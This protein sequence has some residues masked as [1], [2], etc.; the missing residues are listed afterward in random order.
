MLA[1]K[2]LAS[3]HWAAVTGNG[4]NWGGERTVGFWFS[5]VLN[6]CRAAVLAA[7]RTT[8]QLGGDVHF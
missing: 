5:K 3:Y 2:S 7:R 6:D 8:S 4:W 1:V